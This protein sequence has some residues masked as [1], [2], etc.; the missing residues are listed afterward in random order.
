MATGW[1]SWLI[2]VCFFGEYHHQS[3]V[4]LLDIFRKSL[5][6]LLTKAGRDGRGKW[7]VYVESELTIL[8]WRCNSSCKDQIA[9][10]SAKGQRGRVRDEPRCHHG[11]WR[12]VIATN[13]D[14]GVRI[15]FWDHR[16]RCGAGSKVHG[17]QNMTAPRINCTLG[18]K[19]IIM[20][21]MLFTLFFTIIF[22]GLA[23]CMAFLSIW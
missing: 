7:C 20:P 11:Q 15:V 18:I 1:P 13:H 2:G 16:T 9:E 3:W 6:V 14:T 12:R 23:K 19:V 8:L 10:Q 4:E 22:P 21:L 5:L 17:S